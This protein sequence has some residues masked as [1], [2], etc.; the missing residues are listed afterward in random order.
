MAA[1]VGSLF[2]R[3]STRI[4]EIINKNLQMFLPVMDPVWRDN[5]I[6]SQGTHPASDL[7]RDLVV[8]KRFHGSYTGVLE[9]AASRGDFPLYGDST[10]G[11]SDKL[12]TQQATQTF[13][14]PLDGANARTYGLAVAMRAMVANLALTLGEL[15]MDATDAVIGEVVAPKLEGFARLMSHTLCNFW[16]ISQN[17]NYSLSSTAAGFTVAADANNAGSY[18]LYFVPDNLAVDRYYQGM[19]VD[20]YDS[21]GATRRNETAGTRI[22]LWVSRVDEIGVSGNPRVY[23]S[24]RVDPGAAG[25]NWGC[26][27]SDIIVFANQKGTSSFTGIAGYNSWMKFGGGSND[28]YLLGGERETTSG[29]YID[30]TLHP[31]FKSFAKAV[32]GVL[33]EQKLRSYVRAFHRAKNKY[34]Q[35]IDCF[36]ASDGV[37]LA[38]EAQKIGREVIERVG[39]GSRVLSSMNTEGSEEGFTFTFDGR[40]FKGYTSNYMPSGQCIGIRKGGN[41]WKRIVPPSPAGTQKFAQADGNVPFEFVA[42]A[43]TGTGSNRIP[44]F[45]TDVAGSTGRA[46]LTEAAQMPGMLRMQLIPDQ[47]AGMKLTGLTEERVYGD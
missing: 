30:V 38:Y 26:A 23:L 17:D 7:G 35:Y 40:T 21:T 19:R 3:E 25:V 15:Q 47:P 4:Q 9:N 16:Y 14:D 28:N 24:A 8:K 42:S 12:F 27:T 45:K 46:L 20:I 5:I 22:S 11:L 6:T 31:E 18:T 29:E 41:N 1:T 34:G 10:T 32:N 36:I 43:L 37:W 2:N 44:I 13:P 33:T 39:D